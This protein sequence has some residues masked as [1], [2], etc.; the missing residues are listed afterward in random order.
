MFSFFIQGLI[1]G[2]SMVVIFVLF[3][4][5]RM[6]VG[7]E[8]LIDKLIACLQAINQRTASQDNQVIDWHVSDLPFKGKVIIIHQE[9]KTKIDLSTIL[10]NREKGASVFHGKY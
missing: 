4:F 9:D 10:I 1:L 2:V 6:A 7:K 5:F 8:M 3:E